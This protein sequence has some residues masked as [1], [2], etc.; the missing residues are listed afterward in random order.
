MVRGGFHQGSTR[1]PRSS[2]R[3]VGWSGAGSTRVPPGFHQGSTRV[4]PGFHQGSTRVPP[5]FHQGSTRVPPGFHEVLQGVQGGRGGFHQGSTR[6]PPGFHE[7][8]Q[9]LRGGPGRVPPGFHEVLQGL[10]R[11]PGAVLKSSTRVSPGFHEVL[12]GL[13]GGPGRATRAGFHQGS[14]RVPRSSAR[15]VGWSGG[16]F[17]NSTR[18]P[19]SSARV[20]AVAR[21]SPEVGFH[22]FHLPRARGS[23]TGAGSTRVHQGSTNGWGSPEAR[24]H[25]GFH[26]GFHQGSTKFCKGCG[27]GPRRV[28]SRVLPVTPRVLQG[29]FHQVS[30][31]GEGSTKFHTFH[32]ASTARAAGWSGAG[33]R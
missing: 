9:G 26:Q 3:A 25:P 20:A 18:V 13:R 27:R 22:E 14:T 12:Q 15:A 32:P 7:V 29:G 33:L 2:A 19:R 5:G 11:W 16:G 17:Q 6:V 31:R 24:F 4:P 23:A 8:L 1:V 30:T 28:I 21:G 10:R